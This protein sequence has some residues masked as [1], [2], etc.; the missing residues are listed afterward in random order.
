MASVAVPNNHSHSVKST[1][2]PT[3][4]KMET[5]DEVGSAVA[6]AD[7]AR[8]IS[9]KSE[10][11]SA[12]LGQTTATV[13]AAGVAAGVGGGVSTGVA[14]SIRPA[15]DSMNSEHQERNLEEIP[16]EELTEEE[17]AV[18]EADR[19]MRE[20]IHNVKQRIVRLYGGRLLGPTVADQTPLEVIMQSDSEEVKAK[21]RNVNKEIIQRRLVEQQ[22]RYV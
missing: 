13:T 5:E 8:G 21:K 6:R 16:E 9:I 10:N 14:P 4:V 15:V 7:N 20:K 2:G 18:L 3:S 19:I 22:A 1:H 12:S 11:L 17:R